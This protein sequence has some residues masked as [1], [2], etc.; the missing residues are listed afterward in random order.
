MSVKS[1]CDFKGMSPLI[2]FVII[3]IE[4][5]DSISRDERD[6]PFTQYITNAG[7]N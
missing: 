4:S 1:S 2:I 7:I 6:A 5:V 3:I